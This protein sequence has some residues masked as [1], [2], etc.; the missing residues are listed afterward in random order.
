MDFGQNVQNQKMA[1]ERSLALNF[2]TLAGDIEAELL[3]RAVGAVS[4]LT[5][6][7]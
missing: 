7:G 4:E 6:W 5:G 3:N 1:L 2:L